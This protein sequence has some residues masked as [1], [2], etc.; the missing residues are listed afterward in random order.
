MISFRELTE[1][2]GGKN[3]HLEHLEDEII[4]YGVD[5]GRAAINFL[6]SLRDMLAGGSRSSINMTVKW[7]GAPAIFCGIDPED[8][9]FFVAKKSVFNVNPKLYKTNGEID[10]DLSGNLNAKFKV[11]LAELSKLGIK[12][13]LQG[14]LMFTDDV[15]TESIDGTSYY[16][17]Q[18]NT[19]VYA[20][21]ID[22]NLGKKINRAK[23]GIV[24]HTT[25]TGN[26]L[27]DMKASFGADISGLRQTSSVWMDD[28]TYKD[29][30]GKSTFTKAETESVTKILSQTGKTFQKIS[31]PKLRSFIKLQESMTGALAGA[32]LKTYNNSKVRAGQK[33]SN[34]GAHAKGYEKWVMESIQKQI[35]KAKSDKGKE[36]YQNIQKEYVREVRKHTGNLKEI[37]TFQNLLVDAKMQIVKKLNSV[38]GLTDTFVKTSNGFKVTNPEGYVAIDRVSGGA[39]KLVDRMEFSFNNFT[40]IKAWDK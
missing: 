8:D 7:D 17:F 14:D 19:I 13:V 31:G 12:G 39:V 6:R 32:S 5:G 26:A 38:K 33:I 4:N 25:Y 18:P 35:D 23:I 3:L 36:K 40:A 27:Q 29:T 34:P 30:S 11:A 2:K 21:P 22:S 16:T 1:D 20:V 10:D 28:A 15:E 9:K 37:I 24:F